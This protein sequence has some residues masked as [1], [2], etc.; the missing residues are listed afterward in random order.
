M[1]SFPIIL[2][3]SVCWGVNIKKKHG[4]G[5]KESR[6]VVVQELKQDVATTTE[7][8]GA[9]GPRAKQG[10]QNDQKNPP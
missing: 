9:S 2:F 10:R 7:H 3:S 6:R 4:E 8:R 1:F 5:K